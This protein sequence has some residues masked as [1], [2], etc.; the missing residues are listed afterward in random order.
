MAGGPVRHRPAGAAG[1]RHPVRRTGRAAAVPAGDDRSMAAVP[2]PTRRRKSSRA[3]R[4]RAAAARAR[5]ALPQ[6]EVPVP[7]ARP[8]APAV[9]R[10]GAFTTRWSSTRIRRRAAHASA[11]R[12]GCGRR[13]CPAVLPGRRGT[14]SLPS[15]SQERSRARTPV[16]Q[17][18]ESEAIHGGVCAARDAGQHRYI[19]IPV[20]GCGTGPGRP[21]PELRR[22]GWP[23]ARGS[24]RAAPGGVDLFDT[25][26]IYGR[27]ESEKP[28]GGWC[29][30]RPVRWH[31]R[32]APLLLLAAGGAH[33]P[34]RWTD[35]APAGAGEGGPVP[36]ALAGSDVASIEEPGIGPREVRTPGVC[37]RPACPTTTSRRCARRTACSPPTA[38]PLP[39]TSPLQSPAPRAGDGRCWTR[40]G[41]WGDTAGLTALWSRASSPGATAGEGAGDARARQPPR[42]SLETSWRPCPW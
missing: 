10:V 33:S 20:V 2:L 1:A 35:A 39:P 13:A 28:S 42:S 21:G 15:S 24:V 16:P 29:A 4:R 5:G 17:E 7:P 6:A 32:A 3:R 30:D 11:Q 14:A 31:P 25:A 41:A 40:A 19:E 36:V 37:G 38:S 22:R 23:G 26:E 12:I 27:G 9:A 8:V 34:A 18:K